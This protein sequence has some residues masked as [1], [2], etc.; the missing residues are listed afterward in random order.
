M[1]SPSG[2][3][4]SAPSSFAPLLVD[5]PRPEPRGPPPPRARAPDVPLRAELPG[6]LAGQPSQPAVGP[7][8]RVALDEAKEQPP[9]RPLDIAAAERRSGRSTRSGAI[10]LTGHRGLSRSPPGFSL[11]SAT[12]PP[13]LSGRALRAVRIVAL[14]EAAPS[15]DRARPIVLGRGGAVLKGA[16]W[17][18]KSSQACTHKSL[19]DNIL[20]S[21][22][23]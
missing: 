5:S 1:R 9:A 22:I 15:T 18:Y 12:A 4:R 13:Y 6:D 19:C 3:S 2:R 17:P 16:S 23:A 10:A 11:L 20:C 14:A 8:H 7:P 21:S